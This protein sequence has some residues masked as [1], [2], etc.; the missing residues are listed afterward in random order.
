[1]LMQVATSMSAAPF[2]PPHQ[3]LSGTRQLT[4]GSR[5]SRAT[6]FAFDGWCAREKGVRL[7]AAQIEDAI[8]AARR[9]SFIRIRRLEKR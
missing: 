1:M 9:I 7:A 8:V 2:L 3:V 4:L 5:A 6:D